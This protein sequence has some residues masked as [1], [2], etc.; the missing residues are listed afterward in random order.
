MSRIAG[1]MLTL[2]APPAQAT[3]AAAKVLT[4]EQVLAA[5]RTR[6]SIGT[7]SCRDAADDAEIVV[8]KR[9]GNP[10][11]VPLYEPEVYDRDRVAGGMQTA[12]VREAQQAFA[13]CHAR[14]EACMEGG[15]NL[16]AVGS[17]IVK[18]I[19]ALADGE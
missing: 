3:P 18:G 8:C 6:T 10:Y 4:A 15:I 12:G 2:A 7:D 9:R 17:F 11:A 13:P 5:H 19:R 16:F 1:V 14:G